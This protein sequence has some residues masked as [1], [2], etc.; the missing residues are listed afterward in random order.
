[1]KVS[2][3]ILAWEGG[4]KQNTTPVTDGG[5]SSEGQSSCKRAC[6]YR[7]SFTWTKSRL[8]VEV[9]S[10]RGPV[11]LDC[12]ERI[13]QP[14]IQPTARDV[15]C[16]FERLRRPLAVP[17][18]FASCCKTYQGAAVTAEAV[19]PRAS[20]WQA[21]LMKYGPT[22]AFSGRCAAGIE[23]TLALDVAHPIH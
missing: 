9:N 1:M 2:R 8:F 17:R 7:Q 14:T 23:L 5:P 11:W 18:G 19:L 21:A 15:L 22:C 4:R 3:G 6:V 10:H 12:L 20:R 13:V 16:D